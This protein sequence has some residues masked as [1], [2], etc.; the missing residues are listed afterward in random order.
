MIY[1]ACNLNV[2]AYWKKNRESSLTP[3][4]DLKTKYSIEQ[5]PVHLISEHV[6]QPYRSHYMIVILTNTWSILT[7]LP[8][9]LLN[10]FFILFHLNFFELETIIEFK[11][12]HQ[13]YSIKIIVSVFL[14]I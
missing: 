1:R 12:Y 5:T 7:S 8:Y 9:Y 14:S 2:S 6:E 11:L 10:S 13:F 3:I 4:I